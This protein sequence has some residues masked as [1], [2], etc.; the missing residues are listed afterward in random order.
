MTCSRDIYDTP[1][2]L[3][4]GPQSIAGVLP[5]YTLYYAHLAPGEALYMVVPQQQ[6]A[7]TAADEHMHKIAALQHQLTE[8][9]THLQVEMPTTT[10]QHMSAP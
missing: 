1:Y 9:C 6:Q 8:A 7:D 10:A 5:G 4:T 3:I 2:S